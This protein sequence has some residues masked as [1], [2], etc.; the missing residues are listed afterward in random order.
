[1][2]SPSCRRN[3]TSMSSWA[4][5]RYHGDIIEARRNITAAPANITSGCVGKTARMFAMQ[6][7]A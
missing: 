5:E 6:A 2:I 7:L 3:I 1:V 4:T